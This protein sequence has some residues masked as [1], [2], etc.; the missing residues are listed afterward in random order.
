MSS[1]ANFPLRPASIYNLY[2]KSISHHNMV[3]KVT[4]KFDENLFHASGD[5]FSIQTADS[6]QW[7]KWNSN[8]ATLEANGALGERWHIVG[9]LTVLEV[10]A[11]QE[12][13]VRHEHIH[14]FAILTFFAFSKLEFAGKRQV[15]G[16]S[17]SALTIDKFCHGG[18]YTL[19]CT[20]TVFYE[21]WWPFLFYDF[22]YILSCNRRSLLVLSW[23]LIDNILILRAINIDWLEQK[24]VC[25][26]TM[27]APCSCVKDLSCTVTLLCHLHH[28]VKLGQA[29]LVRLRCHFL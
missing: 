27:W 13:Q 9:I 20:Q 10:T 18:P 14:G 29:L 25:W 2:D 26:Y 6:C 28:N 8:L 21:I 4:Y 24:V 19:H 3:K 17:I 12:V 11:A 7:S 1:L 16:P 22:R 23:L 5:T 15:Y